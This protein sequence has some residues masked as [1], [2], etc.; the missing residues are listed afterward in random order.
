[1]F[2][3]RAALLEY[4]AAVAAAAALETAMEANDQPSALAL[5]EAHLA[6]DD[7]LTHIVPVVAADADDERRSN[8]GGAESSQVRPL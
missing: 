2:L 4:E 1:V 8:G 5:A 7:W 3:C 6:D